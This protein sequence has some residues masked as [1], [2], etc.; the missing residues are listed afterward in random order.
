MR[1]AI[2]AP[3]GVGGTFGGRLAKAGA[4]VVA[5]ARGAHLAAIRERGLRVEGPL[6]DDTVNIQASDDA[7]ALGPADIVL[8]AV[9]LYQAGGGA[10]LRIGNDRHHAPQRHRGCRGDRERP[11]RRHNPCGQRLRLRGDRCTGAHTLHR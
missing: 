11:V 8:F 4:E 9:K 7:A 5:L 3:G 10:L 2:V 6:G 1:I